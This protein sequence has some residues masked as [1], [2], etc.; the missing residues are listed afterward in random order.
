MLRCRSILAAAFLVFCLLF[1]ASTVWA[2]EM[3]LKAAT[4]RFSYT[5]ASQSGINGFFGPYNVDNSSSGG[6]FAPLNGWL[7]GNVVSGSDAGRSASYLRAI[8]QLYLHEAAHIGGTYRIGVYPTATAPGANTI[9]SLG[10][11][12]RLGIFVETPLGRITYGKM[13]FGAGS[14]LQF[15]L[16]NRTEEFLLLEAPYISWPSARTNRESLF[17]NTG[18]A[19]ED[20]H[21][22]TDQEKQRYASDNGIS[23]DQLKKWDENP[24]AA[25][26]S[27][28]GA[29][30]ILKFGLGF[31]PWHLGSTRYWDMQDLNAAQTSNFLAYVTY[32][33][34][35]VEAEVGGLYSAFHD[36]PEA[37]QTVAARL[38]APPVYTHTAEGFI[39]LKYNNGRFFCYGEAD[40][41]YQTVRYQASQNGTFFGAPALIPGGGG[42][43]FAP[44][45]IES[46]RWMVETGFLW[47]PMK[48]SLLYAHMPGLDR[49]HGILIDKQPI[50]Q[51]AQQSAP[52]VFGPYSMLIA[53][54]YNSGV[55]SSGDMSAAD[56]FAGRLDYVLARNLN[57]AFSLLYAR[58]SSYGYGWGYVRPDP[59]PGAAF[60]SVN[61]AERG[62]FLAPSPG[63]PENSL[64]WEASVWADWQLLD[65]WTLSLQAAYWWTG[66]WFNYACVDKS[67][68]NWDVPT[69]A[70][71]FG[72]NPDR[73][74]DPVFGFTLSFSAD[75]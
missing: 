35:P 54:T 73:S 60:G 15:S 9:M 2:W 68:V 6:N 43:L 69:P 48:V 64:G 71:N 62:T 23:L 47:G 37:Q 19:W 75:L 38:S 67:V 5:F 51:A 39:S 31:Y 36:G 20:L 52:G 59:T 28:G 14:G 7:G 3:S 13:R 27:T 46:W 41:Y 57:L 22:M 42:S 56:T 55:N 50:I 30:S 72:V 10:Q 24:D 66:R 26:A 44:H 1:W 63:I 58:R 70:N 65:T 40:W 53:G 16:G 17:F 29:G 61:F 32:S 12:L 49:R 8:P 74:I 21:K 25:D 33:S 34:G 11:W 18:L 45:Y 4:Y